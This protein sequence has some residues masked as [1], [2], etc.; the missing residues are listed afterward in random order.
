MSL[1][2]SNARKCL[3]HA[4]VA[5]ITIKYTKNNNYVFNT[6]P[7]LDPLRRAYIHPSN[8]FLTTID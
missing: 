3:P 6:C 1:S 7:S 2:P 4:R 5:R 8:F